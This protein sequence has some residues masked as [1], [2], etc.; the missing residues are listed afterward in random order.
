MIWLAAAMAAW[1]AAGAPAGA[2]AVPS[3]VMVVVP[4]GTSP[5]GGADRR[6]YAPCLNPALAT[7]LA[8]LMLCAVFNAAT[9]AAVSG[10]YLPLIDVGNRRLSNS[11][12]GSS[13]LLPCTPGATS[14]PAELL[15]RSAW[16]AC[17]WSCAWP[18]S[19]RHLVRRSGLLGWP[20]CPM[21]RRK[22]AVAISA[23]HPPYGR[24]VEN[25]GS[26]STT[27]F[28]LSLRLRG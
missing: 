26:T 15:A 10:P 1:T 11:P 27:P 2:V 12:G 21:R 8:G 18:P 13:R 6:L 20:R 22:T 16:T 14:R 3:G 9:L 28:P 4:V 23:E 19:P 25:P 5:F 17:P 24:R 7:P